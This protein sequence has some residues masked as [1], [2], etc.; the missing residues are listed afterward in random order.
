MIGDLISIN[1]KICPAGDTGISPDD[2]L[3][4]NFIYQ[5]IHVTEHCPLHPATHIELLDT[6]YTSLYG[7][8]TGLT[9][10]TLN[11][12]TETLLAANR[13]PKGSMQMAVYVLP[14]GKTGSAMRILSCDKQLLYRGY[15]LWHTAE[16]A[17]ILPY[18]YPFAP[19]KTAV[20][21]A[22]NTYAT[23]YARRKGA[24]VAI[25]ENNSGIIYGAGENPL[26]AVVE[27][28]VFTTPLGDGACDSV[29]RRIGITACEA[30]GIQV[31]E[32]PL[33]KNMLAE[34]QEIFVVTPGGVT[35]IRECNKN[36]YPN[37]TAGRIAGRMQKLTDF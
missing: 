13:Y 17:I 22:A 14:D 9:V 31:E 36:I 12:E 11:E 4:G 29:E 27:N 23:D 35:S 28:T 20:S 34:C 19:F 25:A 18:E 33:T 26:F 21:L 5:K 6:A 24:G 7:R 32:T 30:E 1:G 37:S 16:K 8:R 10:K 3:A 2:I 15:E